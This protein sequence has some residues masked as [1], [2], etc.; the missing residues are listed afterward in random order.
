MFKFL[1]IAA[2]GLVMITNGFAANRIFDKAPREIFSD[3]RVAA[4]VTAVGDG[5]YTVAEKLISAGADVNVI[6]DDGVSPLLWIMLSTLDVHKIEY[7]LKKGASPNYRNAP[8]EV[9]AMYFAA[10]GDRPDILELLLKS[11][12]DP[13]LIGPRDESLLM[14]AMGQFR[15]KNIELLLKYGADINRAD[16]HKHTVASDAAAYG[17]FD[18][19]AH[20]LDLGLSY[21]LQGLGKTVEMRKVPPNSEQQRWKDK[22]IEMLAARGVK[23]PAFIPCYP[24]DDPRRKDEHCK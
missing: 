3:E 2:A 21:D 9:S 17:R 23:F 22:V 14:I 18:F 16:R 11:K 24:P 13:N 12:G 19:V 6:G 5:D 10:G 1:F 20:F 7:T 15:E 8:R 4:F